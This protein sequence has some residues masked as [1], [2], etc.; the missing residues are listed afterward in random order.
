MPKVSIIGAGQ[1][2]GSA[3][4]C[5]AAQ[6]VADVVLVDILGNQTKGKAIDIG[7]SLIGCSSDC[8]I[9]GSDD[10][11]QIKGSEIVVITAG[12]PRTKDISREDML[13][14]NCG[15]MKKVCKEVTK[16]APDAI[17]ITVSNPLDVTTAA[18]AKYLDI[19]K[20]KIIGMGGELDC[21][22]F[23]YAIRKRVKVPCSQIQTTVIGM[24]GKVMLPLP[25]FS[26]VKG[27]PLL[28][29]L[30]PQEI[31]DVVEETKNGGAEIVDLLDEGSAH[32]APGEA[33]KNM[34][35]AVL[36]DN[37]TII[38]SCVYL[39][40]KDCFL[41]MPAMLGRKGVVKVVNLKLEK[42]TE[43]QFNDAVKTVKELMKEIP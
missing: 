3:A 41:G 29:M 33:I 11:S 16:Y 38:C 19:D 24:H 13:K 35:E 15:I 6:G 42:E 25:E 22:R 2:G 20:K 23:A 26:S 32:Y 5:I 10:F 7:Q 4:Q 37:N 34:V 17:V 31:E 39:E 9:T 27:I 21:L 1:V 8:T 36:K 12:K 30:A 18:A 43:V 28:E 40:D 14:I